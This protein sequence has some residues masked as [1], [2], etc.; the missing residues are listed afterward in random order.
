[1]QR[2]RV[3]AGCQPARCAA[4]RPGHRALRRRPGPARRQRQR[5]RRVHDLR[6]AR[7]AR[8][9]AGASRAG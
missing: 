1:V 6:A 8:P 4:L 5:R 3:A 2:G 7:P 9:A